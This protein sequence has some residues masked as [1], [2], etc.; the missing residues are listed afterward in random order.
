MKKAPTNLLKKAIKIKEI[1]IIQKE[2]DEK[3]MIDK[4][5]ESPTMTKNIGVNI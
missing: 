3:S 4:S 2:D 1:P 5:I